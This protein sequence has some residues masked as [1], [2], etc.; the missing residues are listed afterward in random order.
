MNEMESERKKNIDKFK[1]KQ[2]RKETNE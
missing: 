2:P 1:Q